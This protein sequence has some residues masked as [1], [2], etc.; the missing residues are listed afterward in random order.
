[1]KKLIVILITVF[2]LV[3]CINQNTK[4]NSEIYPEDRENKTI[5]TN[6]NFIQIT[7]SGGSDSAWVDDNKIIFN[8]NNEIWIHDLKWNKKEKLIGKNG[9]SAF[10]TSGR[11]ICND[12]LVFSA[13]FNGGTNLYVMDFKKNDVIRLTFDAYKEEDATWSPKCDYVVYK[14]NRKG[15]WDIYKIKY[16]NK[17]ISRLTFENGQDIKPAWSP[18]Q[19]KIIFE[20]DKDIFEMKHTGKG[21]TPL[22]YSVYNERNPSWS[23]DGKYIVYDSDYESISEEVFVYDLENRNRIKIT[24]NNYYDGHPSWSPNGKYILFESNK[25]GETNIFMVPVTYL[26]NSLYEDKFSKLMKAKTFVNTYD[27]LK[28]EDVVRLSRF[29]VVFVGQH[30]MKSGDVQK[31]KEKGVIVLAYLNIGEAETFKHYWK[32]LDKDLII[33]QNKNWSEGYY[34]DVNDERWHNLIVN[35]E[36]PY[37]LS[38]ADYDGFLLDMLD[39]IEEYPELKPGMINLVKEIKMKYP[40]KIIIPNR[41][42]NILPDIYEYIDGFNYE[43]MC[44]KYDFDTKEYVYIES[45]NNE[46]VLKDVLFKKNIPVFVLDHTIDENMAKTCY[47]KTNNYGYLW[48]ANSIDQDLRIW[49]F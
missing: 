21:S 29:D 11:V 1:V 45:K 49:N 28:E 7:D 37:V 4:Q 46:N 30:S 9:Y 36:I 10:I 33:Q 43:E 42:F 25:T 27:E 41:G 12:K 34:V 24:N 32:D 47:E 23:P 48:Y 2:F 35:K 20:N 22:I 5:E 18:N 31:L 44:S 38:L 40:D 15:T 26:G 17:E 8:L 19:Q 3:S 14:S 13:D 39:T 16:S 6:S